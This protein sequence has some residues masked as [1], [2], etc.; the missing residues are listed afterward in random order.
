[1]KIRVCNENGRTL[2]V[3]FVN[4]PFE[5]VAIN[6]KFQYWEYMQ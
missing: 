4:N 5:I 3:L 2:K 1:M 6:N